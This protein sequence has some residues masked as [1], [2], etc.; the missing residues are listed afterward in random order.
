MVQRLEHTPPSRSHAEMKHSSTSSAC[1][2]VRKCTAQVWA[3][4]QLVGARRAPDDEDDLDDKGYKRALCKDDP[5][6]EGLI[7]RA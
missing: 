5:K 7:D 1:A 3:P 4:G 2:S 6:N